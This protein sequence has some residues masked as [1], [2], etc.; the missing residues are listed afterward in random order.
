MNTRKIYLFW[1]YILKFKNNQFF[2]F[3]DAAFKWTLFTLLK[4][5]ILL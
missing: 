3:F 1:S 2:I 4:D 5:K